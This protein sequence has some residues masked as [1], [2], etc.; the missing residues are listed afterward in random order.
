LRRQTAR[1][2]ECALMIQGRLEDGTRDAATAALL[3]R[4]IADAEIAAERLGV[5]LLK[6]RNYSGADTLTLHLPDAPVPEA[7]DKP[8]TEDE[9]TRLLRRD[10]GALHLLITR[11]APNDR[12]TGV[13]VLRNRLLGYRDE[14]RLP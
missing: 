3:Q 4:R 7:P 6:A 10:L 2:H 13:T 8:R 9:A 5:L 12:G 14:E 11:L 1:L